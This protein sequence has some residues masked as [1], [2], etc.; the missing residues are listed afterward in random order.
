M[1]EC[2]II[3]TIIMENESYKNDVYYYFMYVCLYMC[4]HVYAYIFSTCLEHVHMHIC[5]HPFSLS[6]V[7][8][9]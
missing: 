7:L 8:C 3:Y 2:D 9:C 4:M 6:T 5:V 1:D